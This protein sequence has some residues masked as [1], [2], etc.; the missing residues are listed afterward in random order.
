[1]KQRMKT[2]GRW[3]WVVIALA[4]MGA[5]AQDASDDEGG[6]SAISGSALGGIGYDSNVYQSPSEPYY[7]YSAS[8]APLVNPETRS[9]Y[10]V[11]LEL[12]GRYTRDLTDNNSLFA[13]IDLKG[14][15]YL[16][17]DLR[18]ADQD[19]Q[20][21]TLGDTMI[22]SRSG[23]RRATLKGE[24]VVAA[25]HETYYDRDD[26]ADQETSSGLDVSNR[27]RYRATGAR[28][29]Y[30]DNLGKIRYVFHGTYLVRDY[31]DPKSVSQYDHRYYSLAGDVGFRAAK[32]ANVKMGYKYY[33]YEY[34]ERPARTLRGSLYSSNPA[35]AYR[36]NLYELALS[37]KLNADWDAR[38][39]ADYTERTDEFVGYND[40]RRTRCRVNARYRA[41][42]RV[43]LDAGFE[44]WKRTYPNA[45]AFDRFGQ[46]EKTYDGYDA[47]MKLAWKTQSRGIVAIEVT[48]TKERTTDAR[49]E[50]DR[51][52]ILL[53][54]EWKF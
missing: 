42:E 19:Q 32:L 50:Y 23:K 40:Y 12:R 16:D 14:Q 15:F 27:Y 28:F 47:H 26:G 10:F 41:A 13:E 3:L 39:E 29:K 44:Y 35:L 24:L 1:M 9:G 6:D 49:Y 43:K 5:A 31:D 25:H 37:K 46:P 8:S 54:N 2:T 11:P 4:S 36:Y 34:D 21:L 53:N 33:A 30:D 7:D 18:N 45:Y 52:Q 20:E 38:I 22:F 17:P 48:K 51:H